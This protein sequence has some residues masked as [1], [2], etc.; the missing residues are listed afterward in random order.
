MKTFV[1]LL[2]AAIAVA[3]QAS[4]PENVAVIT[5]L[6]RINGV[7]LACK[8]LD[9]AQKAKALVISRGSKTRA[10]GQAFETATDEAYKAQITQP[11]TCP[12]RAAWAVTL[13][14]VT[15]RLPQE[16]DAVAVPAPAARP[17]PR[18]LLQGAQGRAVMDSDFHGKFQLVTFGY[19]SCPDVCPTTLAEMAQV[20]KG[21]AA[22]ADDLQALFISVDPE[23]DTAAQLGAYVSHFDRRIIGATG[24]PE[25]VR[26]AAESFGVKFEKVPEPALGPGQYSIDHTAGMFLLGPDGVLVRRFAYGATA[27][28]LVE[29]IEAEMKA[30]RRPPAP[31]SPAS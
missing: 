28:E 10:I 27:G 8:H 31:S 11:Q 13:E 18:Y 5:E 26:R 3:V 30:R 21:L 9:L 20:L 14:A 4:E 12:G 15:L 29:G 23:R 7:A 1:A 25:L 2:A 22:Q 17:A 19:T 6:G 16:A 24:S